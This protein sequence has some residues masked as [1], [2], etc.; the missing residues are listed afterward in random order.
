MTL[1]WENKPCSHNFFRLP[2]AS[3]W[4]KL[5]LWNFRCKSLITKQ[6]QVPIWV[7]ETGTFLSNTQLYSLNLEFFG[8]AGLTASFRIKL[9]DA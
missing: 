1:H 4:K 6:N 2:P 5:E 8:F 7:F 9:N 3:C